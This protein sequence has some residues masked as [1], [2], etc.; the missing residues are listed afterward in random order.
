[1]IRSTYHAT[2]RATT[3]VWDLSKAEFRISDPPELFHVSPPFSDA[4]E[5]PGEF[6]NKRNRSL[7]NAVKLLR[8]LGS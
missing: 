4:T 1:M 5:S 3:I 6:Q 8:L 7:A 2:Q